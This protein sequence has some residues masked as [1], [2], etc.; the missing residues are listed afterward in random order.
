MLSNRLIKNKHDKD[1]PYNH[2]RVISAMGEVMTDIPKGS[3]WLDLGC[4]TGQFAGLL[5]DKHKVNVTGVDLSDE[6]FTN[7]NYFSKIPDE[8]SWKYFRMDL[9]ATFGIS[10][11]FDYISALNIIEHMLDTDKFLRDCRSHLRVGGY[12]IVSTPNICCLRNRVRVPL[13]KYPAQ[14]EYRTKIFHVRLYNMPCLKKHLIEHKFKIKLILGVHFFPEKWLKNPIIRKIDEKLA[15]RFP[16][17]C[18]Q[19]IIICQK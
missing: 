9:R 15:N 5:Y 7:D 3:A 12:L 18:G 1:L 4:G 8:N 17:L 10:G 2:S 14:M 11:V 6:I 13:G 19:F 16:N